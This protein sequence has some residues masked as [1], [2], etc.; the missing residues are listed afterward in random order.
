MKLADEMATFIMALAKPRAL[1]AV[2]PNVTGE[3]LTVAFEL[4]DLHRAW[5]DK[6]RYVLQAEGVYRP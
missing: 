2:P 4:A 3:D 1:V 6:Q 5:L